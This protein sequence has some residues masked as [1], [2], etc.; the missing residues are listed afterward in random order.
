MRFTEEV[1]LI[2]EEM[3]RVLQYFTWQVNFWVAKAIPRSIETTEDHQEGLSA[4][5]LRQAEIRRRLH[6]H[7]SDL[8]QGIPDFV[9]GLQSHLHDIKSPYVCELQVSSSN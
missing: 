7:F 5:A 2:Q 9:R 3:N 4:Y 1:Q 8:W 6:D